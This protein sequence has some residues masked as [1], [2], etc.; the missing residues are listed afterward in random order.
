[1]A[2]IEPKTISIKMTWTGS[3]AMLLAIFES[4]DAEGRAFAR[5]ELRRMA[6]LLDEYAAK[7]SA[8]EEGEVID[9][10]LE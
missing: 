6:E 5:G 2:E 10:G 9:N 4:G 1:M 3:L 8:A 7:I